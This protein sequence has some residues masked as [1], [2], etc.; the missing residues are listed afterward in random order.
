MLRRALPRPQPPGPPHLQFFPAQRLDLLAN[1][2]LCLLQRRTLLASS[3]G[4]SLQR[5]ECDERAALAG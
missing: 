1:T 2:R 5:Q 3:R 4:S